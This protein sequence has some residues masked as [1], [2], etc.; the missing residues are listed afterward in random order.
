[1]HVQC[2]HR[3]FSDV[4]FIVEC[5]ALCANVI[6]SGNIPSFYGHYYLRKHGFFP[7]VCMSDLACAVSIMGKKYT[8]KT[9]CKQKRLQLWE[10][11]WRQYDTSLHDG[12]VR[13]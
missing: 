13:K 9:F 4:I 5:V 8:K 12:L 2:I 3:H 7:Q 10:I 11:G 6:I 1:M